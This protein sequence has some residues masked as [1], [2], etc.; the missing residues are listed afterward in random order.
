MTKSEAIV[1]LKEFE[2]YETIT[3]VAVELTEYKPGAR[4]KRGRVQD[5]I[6]QRL[7][8]GSSNRVR[9]MITTVLKRKGVL[10]IKYQGDKCYKNIRLRN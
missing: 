2:L 3:K 8:E 9:N 7:D 10:A 1:F 5:A 4:E 6:L